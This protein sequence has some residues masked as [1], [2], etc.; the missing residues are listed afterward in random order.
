MPHTIN[1]PEV[2]ELAQDLSQYTGESV[3]QAVTINAL[4]E[5]LEREKEK[6]DETKQLKEELL[7][8]GRECAALP[9]LDQRS[10][11]EVLGY[12]DLG[13]PS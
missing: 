3:T 9:V 7:R 12:T 13:V 1:H 6:V 5:R 8:I 2:N 4:R 11:D 10:P